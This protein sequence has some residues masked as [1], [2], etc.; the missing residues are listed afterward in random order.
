MKRIKAIQF[1]AAI[2]LIVFSLNTIIG[3][4]CAVGMDMGFNSKHHHAENETAEQSHR[5][6]ATY[7]HSGK[8][9][10]HQ[11]EKVSSYLFSST[12]NDNC[13]SDAVTAFSLLNKNIEPAI[14]T[15]LTP[16]FSVCFI[17]P[18][19]NVSLFSTPG[20]SDNT[21]YIVRSWRLPVPDIRVAIRS[22]QI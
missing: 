3:F 11:N 9:S 8:S 15:P 16:V 19:F 12:Q 13:C 5:H 20:I 1:K 2:L 14:S 6:G 18:L 4:A 7:E 22:F 17:Y 10:F 21:S